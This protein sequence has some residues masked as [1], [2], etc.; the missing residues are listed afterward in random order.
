MTFP[1]DS[2]VDFQFIV[3]DF[4]FPLFQRFDPWKVDC[5]NILHRF[6]CQFRFSDDLFRNSALNVKPTAIK[7]HKALGYFF[8]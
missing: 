8:L 2:A 5:A 7:I 4:Q 1:I 6:V 3:F